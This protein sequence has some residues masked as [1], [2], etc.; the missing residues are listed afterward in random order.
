ML[1]VWFQIFASTHCDCDIGSAIQPDKKTQ[2]N[3][4]N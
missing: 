1:L 3:F 2:Y 4:H